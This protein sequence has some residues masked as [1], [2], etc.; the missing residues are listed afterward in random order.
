MLPIRNT[1][2]RWGLVTIGFHWLTVL[3]VVGLC[4]VGFLMQELPSGRFKIEVF[5]V[6][7][8]FGLTLLAIT[9]LRLAWRLLAGTP[10]PEPMPAWQALAARLSHVLLYAVLVAMPLTGWLY[11]SASGFPLRWFGQFALPKLSGRDRDVAGFAV[12]AHET[13]FLVLAALVTVH[14]LAALKHHYLDRD[15]TLRRMLPAMPP[16]PPP[17]TAADT[18]ATGD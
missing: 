18:P 8:S 1:A 11:T 14:A 13:L 17:E 6:H 4:L 5:A 9:V 16:P 3:L 15:R 12:E 7:K 10:L 2:E